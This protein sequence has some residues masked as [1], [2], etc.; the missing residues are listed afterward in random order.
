VHLDSSKLGSGQYQLGVGK[1][2]SDW[3]YSALV[4]R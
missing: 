3:S 1:N 4:L 2:D